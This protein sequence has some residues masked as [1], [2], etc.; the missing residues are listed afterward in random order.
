MASKVRQ[1]PGWSGGAHRNGTNARRM[2]W[3]LMLVMAVLMSMLL[4]AMAACGGPSSGGTTPATQPGISANPPVSP[5]VMTNTPTVTPAPAGFQADFTEQYTAVACSGNQPTG[6]VCVTTHGS[7]QVNN[8]GS[9]LGNAS[10]SRTSV[11]APGGTD[12]CGS[13]TT[14]GTLTLATGD[15]ITFRATGTF[16]RA[17]QVATFTYT[18]TGGTGRYLNASGS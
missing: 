16:C 8:G 17:T 18:I 15:T 9:S 13:A 10:L 1:W 4:W 14:N 12:S 6:S 5:T 3:R 2:R 7:G 11:Y